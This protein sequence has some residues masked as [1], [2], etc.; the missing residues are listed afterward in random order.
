MNSPELKKNPINEFLIQTN[1]SLCFSGPFAQFIQICALSVSVHT[2]TAIGFERYL[3][4][5]KK[6]IKI[7]CQI[8]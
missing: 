8:F 7:F 6:K 5:Q 4:Q 2:L 1:L 3:F